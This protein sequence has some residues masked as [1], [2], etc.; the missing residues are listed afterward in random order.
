MTLILTLKEERLVFPAGRLVV[1]PNDHWLLGGVDK[2]VLQQAHDLVLR[3][4]GE[5][6]NLRVKNHTLFCCLAGGWEDFVWGVH[7]AIAPSIRKVVVF[8]W[9]DP[10][11]LV[12][13]PPLLQ[14]SAP[15]CLDLVL[16]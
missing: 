12:L 2:A 3:H 4:P 10:S 7:T 9:W 14:P 16:L 13:D 1:F 6:F 11:A 8:Q 5:R 15:S